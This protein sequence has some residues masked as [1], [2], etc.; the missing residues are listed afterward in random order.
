V[1]FGTLDVKDAER[2]AKA[3]E[4]QS[5]FIMPE[6]I[7]INW[8]DIKSSNPTD[9]EKEQYKNDPLAQRLTTDPHMYFIFRIWSL[10]NLISEAGGLEEAIDR[11]K[12]TCVTAL[13][14]ES[15][16]TFV[17]KAIK[18]IAPLSDNIKERVEDLVGDPQGIPRV[19]ARGKTPNRSW[20]VDILE[21]RIKD[22]G[23]PHRTN[24]AVAD[25]A[26]TIALADGEATA[27]VLKAASE[28]NRLKEVADGKAYEINT[29]ADADKNRLTKEGEGRAAAFKARSEAVG[30]NKGD[31][32][33]KLDALT[34]GLQFG[35]A[36]IL[37]MDTSLLTA[38]L[39]VKATLDAATTEIKKEG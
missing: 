34:A 5:W 16:K 2:A 7:R 26:K 14:E 35:K 30:A 32:L 15:G 25:R 9:E 8:G 21:V 11:I 17:A 28:K 18:Q 12:D 36:T 13:S 20:G 3:N 33:V 23:T 6:P 19:V 39:S 38:A 31:L 37:P 29:L 27:V 10:D 24:E 1:D 22:L 4:S